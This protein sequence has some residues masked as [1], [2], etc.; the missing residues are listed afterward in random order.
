MASLFHSDRKLFPFQEEH[1]NLAHDHASVLMNWDCGVG[2]SVGALALAARKLEE[3]LV[4]HVLLICEKN[5]TIPEEWP[6]EIERYT[7]IQ[8]QSYAGTPAKRKKI[9]EDI[10]P[11]LLASFDIVKNDAAV[12]RKNERGNKMRPEP[13]PLSEALAGKRVFVI[14]DETTRLA[15]RNSDTHRHHALFIDILRQTKG[16]CVLAL[17]ATPMEK[18][19]VSF[20]NLTRI[21]SPEHT[22]TVKEFEETYIAAYDTFGNPTRFRNLSVDDSPPGTTP[23]KAR[24]GALVL[25][26]RKS[27]PDVVNYFPLRREMPPTMIRMGDLQSQFYST[28][29]ALAQGLPDWESRPYTTVLRQ[30]TGNPEALLLSQG[31]IAR[32]IVDIVTPEGILGIGSAKRDRLLTWCQ[33]VVRDQG[34]QAVI[35]TFFGQSMLPLIQR[36]LENE[37]YTVSINHGA[38]STVTKNQMQKDF[39]AGKTDIFLTSD[40]GSKGLNLPE[41]TYLL[42]YERPLTHSN[43]IQR[44]DRIH[45]INSMHESV[46][47]YSFVTLETIEEGFMNL[48]LRRNDWSDTLLGDDEVSSEEFLSAEDRRLLLKIGR[49]QARGS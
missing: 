13:G 49:L 37:G 11:M 1:V 10:P 21:L 42:H 39:R 33:E 27:D 47:I 23:L 46:Y 24:M 41:A 8:W 34:A 32:S 15:N 6:A 48:N 3:G 7:D 31:A 17:T 4:D 16:T 36:D 19:P 43:F 2:K 35:F 14:Y 25:R 9:R 30:I 5:K 22:C 18:D 12:T 45:R 28:V 20:Y 38:L 29:A 40:A 44:S 26:K